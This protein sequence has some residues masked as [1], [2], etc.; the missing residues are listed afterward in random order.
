MKRR[1]TIATALV[2][3]PSILFL[4]EPTSGLDIQSSRMIRKL[5]R[6]LNK[7]GVTVFLTTHYIEEA[8]QLCQRVAIINKGELV[9]VDSPQRLK[10]SIEKHHVI[11][12]SFDNSANVGQKLM[13]VE[14]FSEV[15]QSGDKFRVHVEDT[16]QAIATL[17][18]FA[19][20]N[21]LK[22]VSINTLS[23][24]LEDV[25]VELTGISTDIMKTEK[26]QGKKAVNL[27]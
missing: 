5:I 4:D 14:G 1:L 8:D 3:S 10:A 6:D 11:E 24:T 17:S 23:S 26:E 19:T 20:E 21:S 12:V 16:S 18:S 27:G 7:S 13:G 22:I 2:H 15:L 25:F 9:A